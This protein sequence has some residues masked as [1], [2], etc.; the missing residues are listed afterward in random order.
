MAARSRVG[1]DS[2]GRPR[3]REGGGDARRRPAASRR[4][5]GDQHRLHAAGRLCRVN[6]GV[7]GA[8]GHRGCAM[9]AALKGP[10]YERRPQRESRHCGRESRHRGGDRFITMGW[11]R[12]RRAPPAHPNGHADGA[13]QPNSIGLGRL[14]P[15]ASPSSLLLGCSPPSSDGAAAGD[16][17]RGHRIAPATPPNCPSSQGGARS[18]LGHSARTVDGSGG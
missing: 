3:G 13:C 2:S 4:G 5:G 1:A 17:C 15:Q 16:R 11:L 6:A 10:R 7:G 18:R 9:V 12:R 14:I 8:S